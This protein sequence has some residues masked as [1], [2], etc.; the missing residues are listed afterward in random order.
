MPNKLKISDCKGDWA[1]VT[2]A[3]SGIGREFAS[4]LASRGMNVVL[5][6]RRGALLDELAKELWQRYQVECLAVPVDLAEKQSVGRVK[7]QV[8]ERG[9]RIRLLCNN[10]AFGRWGRF[11][12]AGA[13]GYADMVRVNVMAPMIL[14]REFL[15]DLATHSTSAIINV[16]SPAAY[17]PVPYM[18]VYAATKAFVLNFS[19]ALYGEWEAKGIIVQCLVPGPTES[20]FDQL[21]GAYE[22]AITK[23]G[24]PAEVVAASLAALESGTP[25]AIPAE[26]TFKQRIFAGLFPARMVI[27][28][29]AK[30]FRPPER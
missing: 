26:G 13:D 29:V 4:Q 25:V 15:D 12:D 21:A 8:A 16:S 20:E 23:R 9:I 19:Q 14:C 10:A 6:A 2:G 18:A 3:S 27:R 22:S 30:M 7:A 24:L 28:E 11:E 1:L 17:Q 5:V